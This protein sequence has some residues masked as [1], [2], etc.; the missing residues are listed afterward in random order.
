MD[1]FNLHSRQTKH[2]CRAVALLFVCAHCADNSTRFR[3]AVINERMTTI[4]RQIT[5]LEE[6]L[7]SAAADD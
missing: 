2:C 4:E 5:L 3:L 1:C 7:K 6:S